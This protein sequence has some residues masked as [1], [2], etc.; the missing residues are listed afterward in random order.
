MKK[1]IL[2]LVLISVVF[3]QG[4]IIKI[5]GQDFLK[6]L[7]YI[8][9]SPYAKL[10]DWNIGDTQASPI[11]WDPNGNNWTPEGFER[12]GKVYLGNQGKITHTIVDT[13]TKPGYW[14]LLLLGNKDKIVKATLVPNKAT[15]ENP[16]IN[17]DK[18]FIKEQIVC[19]ENDKIKD[20]VYRI[21]FPQKLSFWMKE[22]TTISTQGNKSEYVISFDKKPACATKA[23]TNKTSS[24]NNI[25]GSTKEQ[26]RHFLNSFYKSGEESFPAK[27]LQ[28]YDSKVDRYF[29]MKNVSKE[30]I[31]ED[32]IRYY[33]K[34]TTRRYNFK[35]FE[36][37]DSHITDGIQYYVVSTVADWNVTSAKGKSRNGIS[38]N[39]ITLIENDNGFLVKGIKSLS[40]QVKSKDIG[41]SQNNLKVT[42]SYHPKKEPKGLYIVDIEINGVSKT[43]RI[44]CP[45]KMVRDIT[46]G[47]YGKSRTAHEEGISQVL[48]SVCRISS[49]KRN[50]KISAKGKHR[51][52][53]VTYNDTLNVRTNPYATRNNKVGELLP[54]ARNIEIIKCKYNKKGTRWCKIRH[55]D[56]GYT[57][58]GWVVARCLTPQDRVQHNKNVTYRVIKIPSNDTLSVRANAGTRNRK[59]GDLEYYAT[60]IRVIRCKK[61]SNGRKW[62]KVSHPSTITGWVSAKYLRQE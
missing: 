20:T 19:E 15:L 4:P 56:Y 11:V 23:T 28:Y 35:D 62:C 31:L 29:S 37:I 51:V 2:F 3:A 58:L 41:S 47:I 43:Y 10:Y 25:S 8:E 14:T 60:G 59:L 48:N 53:N 18:A 32:K 1:T 9:N 17:I 42:N 21:K 16:S 33:K 7:G 57:I 44:Y 38:Y 24:S 46:N 50:T 49:P 13:E 27:T 6:A 22:K 40:G 54:D 12:K 34:W 30:D 36:V 61:A 5:E 45:T 55:N 26:I 52:I 39:I